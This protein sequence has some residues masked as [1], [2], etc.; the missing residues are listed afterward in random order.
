[1]K[2]KIFLIFLSLFLLSVRPTGVAAASAS[3]SLSPATAS[4][5][6]GDTFAVDIV[7]DT[8]GDAAS[9]A[10]ALINYDKDKLQVVDDATGTVHALFREQEDERGYF[11]LLEDIIQRRGIPLALYSDRHGIFQVS[12][13]KPETLEEQ[14][15]GKEE[16]TQFGRALEELGIQAIFARSPQAKG[17]CELCEFE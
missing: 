10:T 4:P 5:N 13:R 8:G 11:L 12:P 3:L 16:P 15:L 6:V 7:L 2:K 9:G 14:L 1:M 17:R